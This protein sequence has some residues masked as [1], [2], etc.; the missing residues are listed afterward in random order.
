MRSARDAARGARAGEVARRAGTASPAVAGRGQVPPAI[1]RAL[2]RTARDRQETG[3]V[4]PD[5]MSLLPSGG[6]P[7]SARLR[8]AARRRRAR[9]RGVLRRDDRPATVADLEEERPAREARLR[10]DRQP[11]LRSRSG[12]PTTRRSTATIF[13]GDEAA[14]AIRAAVSA[15]P[16]AAKATTAGAEARAAADRRRPGLAR[17]PAR[18]P[19][20]AHATGGVPPSARRAQARVLRLG[21]RGRGSR[22]RRAR[23]AIRRPLPKA[24]LPPRRASRAA[25]FSTGSKGSSAGSSR[26]AL[27]P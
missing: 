12:C 26:R 13:A 17:R 2:R 16:S 8:R 9:R 10:Q 18:G 25:L 14:P 6:L 7:Q 15:L 4:R 22:P 1:R 20:E 3:T 21:R 23:R 5:P 27:G 19:R 24:L 11:T